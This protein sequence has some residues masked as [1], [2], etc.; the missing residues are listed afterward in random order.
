MATA[1]STEIQDTLN[2][3]KNNGNSLK[4][5][6]DPDTQ[7]SFTTSAGLQTYNLQAAVLLMFPL[8]TPIVNQMPRVQGKGKQAEYKAINGINTANLRGW[9]QENYS[10]SKVT[11]NV[12][13]ITAV[14]RIL[15][16]ADSISFEAEWEGRGYTD[17]KALAVANLIRAMK[18]Q[19][20]YAVLFGQ[21]TVAASNQQSPGA[22]G[23]LGAPVLATSGTGSVAAGTY[24]VVTVPWTGMGAGIASVAGSITTTAAGGIVVTPVGNA[25][26]PILG[27]DVYVGAASGGP[28][29]K[30]TSSNVA[31]GTLLGGSI[32]GSQML[33]NG[34]PVTLTSVPTTG[35]NPPGTDNTA[36]ALAYNGIFAQTYGGVGAYKNALNGPLSSLSAINQMFLSL[37]N[38]ANGDPDTL[39]C[40]AAESDTITNLTLGQSGTPYFITVDNQNG[41]TGNYRTARLVNKVTGS[42]V[43]VKVH[44]AIPQGN[45]LALQQKLPSWYVPTDIPN[46]MAIDVVQDYTE[47]DYPPVYDPTNGNGDAWTIAIKFLSTFKMYIPLLQGSITGISA[48]TSV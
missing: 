22:V 25:G 17:V 41:A 20:E 48:P 44:P 2:F 6:L 36:S 27:Y 21:N 11:S 16:L 43:P 33:T 23:Q 40:N 24:Y 19:E 1:I 18:I 46:T 37:W 32:A 14:Y 12:I 29:Y 34:A 31:S 15:A 7:K 45:I 47:I 4:G 35:A 13:D 5:A 3:L 8:L 10:A 28:F 9:A 39:Y 38:N 42:E 30:V 26:Q